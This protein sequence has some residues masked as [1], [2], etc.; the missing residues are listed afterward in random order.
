MSV[1]FEESELQEIEYYICCSNEELLSA[2][3]YYELIFSEE[4]L[5]YLDQK[6]DECIEEEFEHESMLEYET[7]RLG[8]VDQWHTEKELESEDHWEMQGSTFCG[9]EI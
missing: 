9:L 3:D 1:H 7:V 8:P 2:L 4:Q 6:R 5:E